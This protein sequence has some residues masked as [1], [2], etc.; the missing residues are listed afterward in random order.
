MKHIFPATAV[1]LV[2]ASAGAL[3]VGLFDFTP[4]GFACLLGG[5][6]AGTLLVLL[7]M[8]NSAASAQGALIRS[9]DHSVDPSEGFE[10]DPR[11]LS[12]DSLRVIDHVQSLHA[13][14]REE[15]AARQ[16]ASTR[17]D[18][19]FAVLQS[20]DDPVIVFDP[21]GNVRMSNDAARSLL[22]EHHWTRAAQLD[23][24]SDEH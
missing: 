4:A 15:A 21:F 1:V 5:S 2:S 22:S 7:L 17:T 20:L 8:R 11:S 10:D 6:L 24:Y 19:L 14:L 13:R 18:E 16:M 12:Q 23:R 3:G 9:L